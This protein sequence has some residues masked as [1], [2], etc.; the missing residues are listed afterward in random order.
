[1]PT[2]KASEE[3]IR[4][5]AGILRA[6]GL[7]AFPTETVYGL[8]ADA[9][10]ESALAR[11]FEAKGR[12]RFDPLIVHVAGFGALGAVA[13][14]SLLGAREREMA[15]ILARGLW[16]G[17]LTLVLPKRS[18]VPD[19][20][21]SGLPTVAARAPAH[22]AALR[23]IE[24]SGGAVA[25]PS[26]NPFGGLSPTKASHVEEALGGKADLILDGGPS[27]VGLESTVLSLCGPRPEILRPGGA[28]REAIEALVGPVDLR[29]APG[30][31]ASV[32]AAAGLPS[33]G[34]L[35]SHYAPRSPLSA[36]E[37]DS[38]L[39]LPPPPD[40][41][42]A[43]YLFFD[44]A[45]LKAWLARRPAG[46]SSGGG[47]MGGD[48]ASWAGG[49]LSCG[50]MALSEAGDLR[51][52]AARLF[53]ALRDLDA[54]RPARIHAQLAPEHGLGL[55]INDRLRRAGAAGEPQAGAG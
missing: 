26:A 53:Q 40:G 34:L 37:G 25:A 13:D 30:C 4:Q 9:F 17:P 29:R 41:E 52:A 39:A 22:E 24:L 23:L 28:P 20:A 27:A 43:A 7:V 6:G 46:K 11:V 33:P 8:G 16:P 10:S 31:G 35:K 19:L 3:A 18:S 49:G 47:A 1:M 12:P 54:L 21:T 50:A 48:S 15:G 45:S 32:G 36:H 42:S 55:A 38:I 2:L 14:L 5:A 44:G 51:E